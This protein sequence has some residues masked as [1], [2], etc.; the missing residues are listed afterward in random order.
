[1][2]QSTVRELAVFLPWIRLMD[3]SCAAS[4]AWAMLGVLGGHWMD[5]LNACLTLCIVT[6]AVCT[7][8]LICITPPTLANNVGHNKCRSR[9]AYCA[10]KPAHLCWVIKQ[11]GWEQRTRPCLGATHEQGG[12]N[13]GCTRP[14]DCRNPRFAILKAITRCMYLCSRSAGCIYIHGV[15]FT[16]N[17]Q[18]LK[19]SWSFGSADI[20][21]IE[22]PD[23]FTNFFVNK[24]NDSKNNKINLYTSKYFGTE[25]QKSETAKIIKTKIINLLPNESFKQIPFSNGYFISKNSIIISKKRKNPIILKKRIYNNQTYVTLFQNSKP[26][27]YNVA[28]LMARTYLNLSRNS[29][30]KIL[31]LNDKIND[32]RLTNLKLKK[33]A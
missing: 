10:V 1:M 20:N 26:K 30:Y 19:D 4:G 28:Y 3:V 12:V 2:Y 16:P 32:N 8:F 21:P 7:A 9:M 24:Y 29:Y 31:H 5:G 18:K 22:T 11:H 23:Y 15:V 25:S 17:I 13:T 33:V 14:S 6:R 27:S